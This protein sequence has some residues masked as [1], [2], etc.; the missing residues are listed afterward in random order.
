MIRLGCVII[1]IFADQIVKRGFINEAFIDGND[2]PNKVHS[3]TEH[4]DG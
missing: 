3:E 4:R 1:G 2:Q